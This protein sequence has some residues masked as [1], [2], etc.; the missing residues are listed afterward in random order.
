M[1]GLKFMIVILVKPPFSK[2]GKHHFRCSMSARYIVCEGAARALPTD[3]RTRS[4]FSFLFQVFTEQTPQKKFGAIGVL[5][6]LWISA[7]V[8]QFRY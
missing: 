6:P 1:I 3:P 2:L 8:T 5:K 4:E 7:C